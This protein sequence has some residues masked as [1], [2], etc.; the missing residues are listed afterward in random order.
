M[1]CKSPCIVHAITNVRMPTNGGVSSSP[2]MRGYSGP[3][4]VTATTIASAM[5]L[6]NNVS[7]MVGYPVWMTGDSTKRLWQI[8][9]ECPIERFDEKAPAELCTVGV[10][11]D[12]NAVRQECF[13][14]LSASYRERLVVVCQL[15]EVA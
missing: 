13:S 5:R 9:S 11:A 6:Y 3:I 15:F 10:Y 12:S 4:S 7:H 14:F 2:P 8:Q 1:A